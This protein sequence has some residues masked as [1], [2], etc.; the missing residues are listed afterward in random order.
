MPRQDFGKTPLPSFDAAPSVILVAGKLDFFVEEAAAKVADALAAEGAER[1]RFDDEASPE[2]VTDALLNR[3]LFSPRRVVEL[4]ATRLLGTE[5]PG[6]I[7][8]AAADAWE[9]ETAAGRR[10]AFRRTRA[11]LSALRIERGSDPAETAAAMSRKLKDAQFAEP[12]AQILRELPEEK[13][14]APGLLE[15][16][17]RTILERGNDGVV[18]LLTAVEPPAGVELLTAIAKK[19]LVLDV[20]IGKE[21]DERSPELLRYALARAREREVS[22]EPGAVEALLRLTDARPEIFAAELAKLFGWAGKGG[23]IRAADVR[24]N[25]EDEESESVYAFFDEI[26]RRDAGAA[27]KKLER[28]FSGRPVYM[29]REEV[30]TEEY[31]PTR[32]LG[33]LTGEVRRM[34]RMRE[35][36]DDPAA[37]YVS[38]MSK[39]AFEARVLPRLR[40]ADRGP[41]R[42]V[43]DGKPYAVF[44]LAER[45]GR[46]RTDELA[47]ALARAADVD[48]ML[49]NSTPPLAALTAYVAEVIAGE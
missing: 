32:F 34:L 24:A 38:G 43:A 31:W 46:Y 29:G 39:H 3:A 18:A 1:I 9:R 21:K 2:S 45:A 35:L 26:G 17:L 42:S 14:A 27:L 11:L 40:E 15:P 6:E 41:G 10:D 19:G 28:I 48:V 5:A 33:F 20:S 37:G 8:R 30:D 49:K 13:G 16:A 44:M 4:D 47:R 7:A 23:R 12:L 25:V 36:L 22:L